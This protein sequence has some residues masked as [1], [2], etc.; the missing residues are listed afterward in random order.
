M[1]G[2]WLAAFVA[3]FAAAAVLTSLAAQAPD[4]P[5]DPDRAAVIDMCSNC[6]GLARSVQKRHTEAEWRAIVTDM[7]EK[8]APGSDDDAAAVVRY[9]TKY[10]GP[11]S[12]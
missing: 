3:P 7:R 12:R 4:L 5:E 6:H 9:L 1:R 2:T 8:G 11:T 10:F